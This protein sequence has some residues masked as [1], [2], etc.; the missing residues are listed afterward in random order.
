MGSNWR[1]LCKFFFKTF[2][3]TD[4]FSYRSRRTSQR[5]LNVIILRNSKHLV[6]E[7]FY[8]LPNSIPHRCGFYWFKQNK[9]T[10]LGGKVSFFGWNLCWML[11]LYLSFVFSLSSPLVIFYFSRY[12]FVPGTKRLSLEQIDPLYRQSSSIF[13]DLFPFFFLI[14]LLL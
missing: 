11:H 9:A 4:L 5:S 1:N 7:L 6:I 2:Y 14:N 13:F 10:S 3:F 12:F 8:Q